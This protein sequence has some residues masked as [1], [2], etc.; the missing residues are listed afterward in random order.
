LDPDIKEIDADRDRIS[1]VLSNLIDNS[2][3]F[4]A[5]RGC[6]IKI[7]TNLIYDKNDNDDKVKIEISDTG[8]GIP[9]EI[10]PS[11]FQKFATRGV[12]G[13]ENKQGTGL[14]LF[15]TKSIIAAHNG[16]IKAYNNNTGGA[17]FS[18]ILPIR[19]GQG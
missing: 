2:L 6:C 14:G 17:T 15:I 5:N 9:D 13:R 12:K 7:Q 11:L 19:A 1:Q 10:L 4:T 18:I 3:K 16:D 8:G